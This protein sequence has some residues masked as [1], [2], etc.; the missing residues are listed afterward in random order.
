MSNLTTEDLHWLAGLL[1]A[2]GCFYDKKNGRPYPS[3]KVSMTDRDLVERVARLWG[4][5][6]TSY[7]RENRKVIYESRVHGEKALGWMLRLFPYMS[8]RRQA[9]IRSAAVGYWEAKK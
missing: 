9:K 1:D 8:R 5:S 7:K 2:D 6:M 3:I 4:S